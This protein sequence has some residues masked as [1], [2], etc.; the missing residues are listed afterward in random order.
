MMATSTYL[1]LTL[2]LLQARTQ[3]CRL[4]NFDKLTNLIAILY[5]MTR[6]ASHLRL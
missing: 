2:S 5:L 1:E 3:Q 6:P 4:T